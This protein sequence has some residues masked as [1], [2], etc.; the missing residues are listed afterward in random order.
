[1]LLPKLYAMPQ[2]RP[3]HKERRS[4]RLGWGLQHRQ[5]EEITPTSTRVTVRDVPQRVLLGNPL[6][7]AL[8][9]SNAGPLT[10]ILCPSYEDAL[11]G[12]GSFLPPG[13][14]PW[15]PTG[16]IEVWAVTTPASPFITELG[17][18]L[19]WS[20]NDTNPILWEADSATADLNL[21]EQTRQ[22]R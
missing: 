9:V 5:Y 10:V 4:R 17:L 18:L 13:V 14:Q 21:A 15:S 8:D 1:M 7:V 6:R 11:A 3:L 2:W 20:P 16:P 22:L 19:L 12:R